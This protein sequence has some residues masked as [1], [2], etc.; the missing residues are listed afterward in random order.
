MVRPRLRSS[1]KGGG[2]FGYIVLQGFKVA[3]FRV[4]GVRA[5]GFRVCLRALGFGAGGGGGGGGGWGT[6]PCISRPLGDTK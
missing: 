6:A 4:K 1:C 2:G 5:L 3:G